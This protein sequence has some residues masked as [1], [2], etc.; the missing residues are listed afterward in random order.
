MIDRNVN[1]SYTGSDLLKAGDY[2]DVVTFT[3][4]AN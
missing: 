3:I 4:S 1:I 2:V